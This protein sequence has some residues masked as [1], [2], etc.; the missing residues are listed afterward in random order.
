[1]SGLIVA[2]GVVDVDRRNEV[3]VGVDRVRRG[4]AQD[5]AHATGVGYGGALLDAGDDAAV[6]E[7]DGAGHPF[8]VQR[9]ARAQLRVGQVGRGQLDVPG[10]HQR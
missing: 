4:V 3:Q 9:S 2:L 7:H 10:V 1:M 6:T 8:R 5:P